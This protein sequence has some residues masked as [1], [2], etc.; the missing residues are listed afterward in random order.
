MTTPVNCPAC[1][2]GQAGDCI[3]IVRCDSPSCTSV[4][5]APNKPG[6]PDGGTCRHECAT[7]KRCFRV[8]FCGPL[9]GVYPGDRWP[10]N[11]V[12]AEIIAATGRR[13]LQELHLIAV[14]REVAA[15][16]ETPL[17]DRYGFAPPDDMVLDLLRIIQGEK[18]DARC[19]SLIDAHQGGVLE[20]AQGSETP[21]AG[22]RLLYL[23]GAI[24]IMLEGAD[25]L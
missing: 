16:A 11:L 25:R 15:V 18:D 3:C 2:N 22:D 24:R 12:S 10:V 17:R 13:T 20:L 8:R 4:V 19:V 14:A 23:V 5:P 1:V 7:A 6:C 21:L 9:S